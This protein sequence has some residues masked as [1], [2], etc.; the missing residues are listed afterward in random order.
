MSSKC[1]VARPTMTRSV[2]GQ[3]P[4]F[5][6]TQQWQPELSSFSPVTA[7]RS[8]P[9]EYIP[10]YSSIQ[11]EKCSTSNQLDDYVGYHGHHSIPFMVKREMSVILVQLLVGTKCIEGQTSNMGILGMCY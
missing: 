7:S 8:E 2:L 10:L 6:T 3:R 11:N 9:P 5:K 4:F 1:H